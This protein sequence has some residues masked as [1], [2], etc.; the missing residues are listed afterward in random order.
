MTRA[1]TPLTNPGL[2]SV[3]RSEHRADRLVHSNG[4]GYVSVQQL[5]RRQPQH[6]AVDGRHAVDR[7]VLRRL[8][9][10]E[11]Q[12]GNAAVTPSTKVTV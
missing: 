3:L 7:P 6:R 11:V 4:R 5:P 10:D 8:S 12:L 9:D 1:N 2:S